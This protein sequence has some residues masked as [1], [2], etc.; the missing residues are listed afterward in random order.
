[1]FLVFDWHHISVDGEELLSTGQVAR[2]LGVSRQH[3][4]DL[5][6]QGML[7][8]V[9]VGT[10]RRIRHGDVGAF[11][12]E[13]LPRE[14]ER[15]LWLHRAVAGRLVLD[16]AAVMAQA[17]HNLARM[18]ATHPSGMSAGWLARWV[19]VLDQGVDDVLDV[20]TSPSPLAVELRQ[21]SPFA[22]ILTDAE[23]TA[24]QAAFRAHWRR[25]HPAA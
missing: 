13:G 7:R 2:L 12:A 4:V 5:C 11:L 6:A 1:V 23:R 8:H 25:D 10:H 9:K 24:V 17:R 20:L 21:N 14:A 15:S 3:V 19:R 18:Q 16:P 22:G